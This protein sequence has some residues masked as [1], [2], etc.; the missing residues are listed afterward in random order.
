MKIKNVLRVFVVLGLLSNFVFASENK[1]NNLTKSSSQT[2]IQPDIPVIGSDNQFMCLGGAASLE[3]LSGNLND[4]TD[5]VWYSGSCG[6]TLV[7]T[8]TFLSVSP[9]VT[10]TYYVRGEGGCVVPG[11]CESITIEVEQ[12]V[13][14]TAQPQSITLC[15]GLNANFDVTLTGGDPLGNAYYWFVD[16]GAGFV[17]LV[18]DATYSGVQTPNLTVSS[19]TTAMTNYQF[20]CRIISNCLPVFF[21]NPATLTVNSNISPDM[22]FAIGPTN[23]CV[24]SGPFNLLVLIGE[25]NGGTDWF[26]YEGSCGGTLIGTGVDITLP[27]PPASTTYYVRG[28]GACVAPGLCYEM[29]ITVDPIPVITSHPTSVSLCSPGTGFFSVTA[30]GSPSINFVWQIDS[31]G[32]GFE[33]LLVDDATYIGTNT[34]DL[35]VAGLTHAMN[36]DKFRCAV[37]D[38]CGPT[39]FSNEATLTIF[40]SAITLDP[41]STTI[42]E[43]GNTTLTAA[44]TGSITSQN[45]QV[46]TDGGATYT[47]LSNGGSYSG[48]TTN[49]L[50]ISNASLSL[51]GNLYRC[52]YTAPCVP[53]GRRTNPATLTVN[54]LPTVTAN[55]TS[56]TV[57]AGSPVTLTGGGNASS[58]VWSGGVTNGVAFVPS[59]TTTYT[60]T[61]TS[62]A[63]CTNTATKTITVNICTAVPNTQLVSTQ[64]G[65][66]IPDL[67]GSFYCT[68]VANAQDYEWEITN[69]TLGYS[70]TKQRGL[71]VVS[72]TKTDFLNLQFGQTYNVRVRAKVGGIWGSFSTS[73]AITL[74]TPLTQLQTAMC[75]TTIPNLNGWFYCNQI[76]GAQDYEWEFTNT[77]LGYSFTRVRNQATTSLLRTDVIGL[78]FGQTY[79]VR[80]R[81]KVGGI[82]G[83]F[84]PTCTLTLG[85]I[86][87]TQLISNLCGAS[88]NLSGWFYADNVSG[89]Q[90]YEWEFTGNGYNFVI[91]RGA[92]IRSLARPSVIGLTNGQTYSVRVRANVG[93]TWGAFGSSCSFTV[94]TSS[95]TRMMQEDLSLIEVESLENVIEFNAYPNPFNSN[96]TVSVS[97]NENEGNKTLFEVFN[98]LGER[99]YSK[100]VT[101]DLFEVDLSNLSNGIYYAIL[102][103]GE[104]R[105]AK[106][107]VKN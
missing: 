30:T 61:G 4:A 11:V 102:S 43:N 15:A 45:W 86:P 64:C 56:N 20:K 13:S 39:L 71:G 87:T 8:G 105:V 82:W 9:T 62:S 22:P 69:T 52:R 32:N 104:S 80:V 14:I 93:G 94:N 66:L 60:V 95:T 25:L 54:A 47:F 29:A 89:A 67:S 23:V 37:L 38:V 74:G 78:Q 41:V 100:N 91:Q 17:A 48:V 12:P 90:D 73:C 58:Y 35:T 16:M 44:A 75:G 70:F 50:T 49:T 101:N 53:L 98:A 79:N 2:C 6:G 31:T 103:R 19:V 26:W 81:A 51:N 76:F 10:T 106:K 3:I 96:F 5:W 36:G 92:A 77:T 40:S 1:N 21:S 97:G 55:S 72:I 65:Q 34:P 18:D 59:S 88:L 68:P 57:C 83:S 42:C 24:G 99:V 107:L 28:E 84:G 7:G 27:V 46:S 33:D 63:G 85:S